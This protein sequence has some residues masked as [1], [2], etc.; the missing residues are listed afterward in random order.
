MSRRVRSLRTV[1]AKSKNGELWHIQGAD[2][3][4]VCA[5][6]ITESDWKQM[7]SE[8]R[9]LRAVAQRASKWR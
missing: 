6:I 5:R 9:V 7:R 4:L 3:R 2:D 8:L 1:V